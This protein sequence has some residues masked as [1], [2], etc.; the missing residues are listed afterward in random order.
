MEE[1]NDYDYDDDYDPGGGRALANCREEEQQTTM[2]VSC[3]I[4]TA[5]RVA[6][7]VLL[8]TVPSVRGEIS[9]NLLQN[10]SFD[11]GKQAN[12]VPAGWRLYGGLDEK[13]RI[14]LSRA[15]ETKDWQILISDG[16]PTQEV[17]L[18]QDVAGKE[19]LTY[20]ASADVKAVPGQVPSGIYMQL[21]FH[22]SG[23]YAQTGLGTRSSKRFKEIAVK[24]TAPPGTEMVRLYLY[25]HRDPTPKLIIREAR[26]VS[27]VPPPPPPP[28]EAIPPVY[29]KLK[30]LCL[31][32]PLAKDGKASATII[33]PPSG[34]YKGAAVGIQAAIEAL[35]G[36]KLPIES[37]E[38]APAAVPVERHVIL[39]G[40]RSTNKATE[41]LYN[42]YYTLLDL[43]YPGPGGHVVRT[44]HN[45]FGN[46]KNVIFV[47]G[48][49]EK[50]VSAAAEVLIRKL[51]ESRAMGKGELA[52][53]RLAEIR[54]S[55]G[56]EIPEDLRDFETWE[57][58][59]GYG[60]IGYF[61]WCSISK[62]MAMYY[63]TGDE[64]HAREFIRLSF[65]DEKAKKEIADLDGERIENKDDPL[66][67]PYHYNAHMMILFWDLVE[68]SPVFTDEERLK[69]TNAFSRQLNHRKG[70]RIYGLTAPSSA[71]GSRHGQ[72]SAISLY[73]LSRYFQKDYPD[74]I[75]QNGMRGSELHF[76]SLHEYAWVGGESDNLFW[77]NTGIAPIFSHL[78]LTGDREPVRNGIL[79]KLALGQE[80]LSSGRVPDWALNSASAG[81][82]H[83]AAYLLQDGR[84]IRY[85]QRSGVDVGLFRLGQSFWPE[86][87]LE[88]KPPSDL[89]GKWSIYELSEPQWIARRSGLNWEQSFHFGSYRSHADASGDFILLDGLNGASRNP[90]HTFAILEL[91]L[92]GY[93]LLKGFRNQVFTRSDGMVGQKIAMDAALKHRDVIGETAIA[94]AE[95]PNAS[96]CSWRRSLVQRTGRYSLVVDDLEF[97]TD[98]ENTEVEIKW[99]TETRA[100][101]IPD[102]KGA[103][104]VEHFLSSSLPDGWRSCS[105]PESECRSKP[106]G[107]EDR[108][109]LNSLG[110]MLLRGREP[111]SWIEMPF[112]LDEEAE[113]EVFADLLNY[114]DRGFVQVALDGKTVVDRF[115]HHSPVVE[116]HHLSLGWHRLAPG[117]HV[118]RVTA[119]GRQEGVDRCYVGL[120]GVD[121]RPKGAPAKPP[122]PKFEIRLCDPV[123]VTR[124]GAVSN[125][126]WRGPVSK[127]KRR[128]FFSA[129]A[130]STGEPDAA[131][132]CSRISDSAAVMALP[133]RALMVAGEL[134]GYK[135]E[136]V[137][138]AED[139]LFGRNLAHVGSKEPL[140]ASDPP[141]DVDWDFE[142]GRLHLACGKAAFVRLMVSDPDTILVNAEKAKYRKG[143][144]GRT[145]LSLPEGRHLIENARPSAA[146]RKD[147]REGL[148]ALVAE[149][150]RDRALRQKALTGKPDPEAPR[151][152]EAFSMDIGGP[153]AN[154]IVLPS[155]GG[156][157]LA[158]AEGRTIHLLSPKGAEVRKFSADGPIRMLNWWEEHGLLLAGCAD[159]K[160]IA[161]DLEGRRKWVF[162]SEMDPAV[163]RAAK[164]YWFKSAPG[165]EGIH[166][167]HSGVFLDG[168][169]QAFVGSACTL[170]ILDENG[171]LVRR[172]PQFW[173]K[174]SAFNIIDGPDGSLNLLAARKYNGNNTV[175][176]INNKTL[177]PKPRGFYTVPSGHTYVPGWA[178]MNRHHLFYEDLDGSGDKKVISEI[179]GTWNRV[180][181]WDAKGRPLHD[182][183]FGP[184]ERIPRRNMRDIDIADLDGDGKQ[185][186]VVGTSAGLVVA[187]DHQCQ[188]KWSYRLDTPP[189]VLA[190]VEIA[191]GGPLVVVGCDDGT[192]IV[193]SGGGELV[194]TGRV[195]GRPTRILSLQGEDRPA[196]VILATGDGSVHAFRLT[197]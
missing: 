197:R 64:F 136:L 25:T 102:E 75:W 116:R 105:A 150:A 152:Q 110:I 96:F 107:P 120:G 160:V 77:Y 161:F 66:A 190:C 69:V 84:Y 100:A 187:L 145:V 35:T 125:M 28:P 7:G 195:Q 76:A 154:L 135:G 58:S 99:E 14:E 138:L 49:D 121:L 133:T 153:V 144:D 9:G 123:E 10:P 22:P 61:G 173:G 131:L 184:G 129:I 158:A 142:S 5:C 51:R 179:N 48:S 115:E 20:Q 89:I 78:L 165:H 59:R 114:L 166:G 134:E 118:L 137:V 44:L 103:I 93:T 2:Q 95:V 88:P 98:S 74:A 60:S 31:N 151:L 128:I 26:L 15:S 164:T 149:G 19:G 11:Q 196:D 171:K 94:V 90:Y 130:R 182:A 79:R 193:L 119:T 56:I 189:Q 92:G 155:G 27:G 4:P 177:N 108:I 37:D 167:L 70:E 82:L 156:A 42:R 45:P 183:S 1:D 159:E 169:S 33:V 16:D 194:G 23:K 46:G 3:N 54:L 147:C 132:S 141:M 57:A 32:T 47:G 117:E 73:C 170:E 143:Q 68:E 12:G 17:G 139:H 63:M 174:V 24:A 109:A 192:V 41:E 162:V 50:G 55:D 87:H 97:Q 157:T 91:R 163:F 43:R 80:I 38:S 111:G 67:G 104:R 6:A 36:A 113:V 81:F 53:G 39:L 85:R 181:V 168:K 172:M 8:L 83:K 188:K 29:E 18:F 30:N 146:W 62:R 148:E 34:I 86:E 176:I 185:E 180:T 13:R 186:I 122:Q 72:W 21:R 127:G 40:N 191:E 71:V 175:A 101:L 140:F 52:I 178:S 126:E 124:Q 106:D 65:P 112:T